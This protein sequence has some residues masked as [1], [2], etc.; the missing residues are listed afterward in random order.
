MRTVQQIVDAT[1]VGGQ[2]LAAPRYTPREG[3]RLALAVASMQTHTTDEGWQLMDGL[4]AGGYKLCGRGERVDIGCVQVG[5]ILSDY[6]PGTL[7]LQDKR[8]WLGRTAGKGFDHSEQFLS[9]SELQHHSDVFK[10][11]VL[12]DAHSDQALHSGCAIDICCHFW[13]VYYDKRLV[14]AT[15]PFAREEHMVRTYH[16]VDAGTVPAF[17]VGRKNAALLSGAVSGA[18][19]LRQRLAKAQLSGSLPNVD[20]LKHPGYGRS[21][22]YTKDY[23]W[24]LSQYKV[25]ICT[26]SRF[27]YAVRKIIEATACG[28]RVITDLPVDEVLPGIDANLVRVDVGIATAD[29]SILVHELCTSWDAGRQTV[30]A[31]LAKELYDYRALGAKLS[32]DIELLRG[33]YNV[34]TP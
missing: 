13:V 3:P 11:Y 17:H 33:A 23:L 30:F 25:A 5:S 12:K 16:G 21:R 20:Y 28:C 10:G 29:L 14:A 7:L 24:T 31:D 8:E 19:P 27:G 26:S 32:A 9:T 4:R 6:K 18:Y 34:G 15:A 1:R 2:R 22:C